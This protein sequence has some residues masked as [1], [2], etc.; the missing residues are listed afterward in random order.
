MSLPPPRPSK[1]EPPNASPFDAVVFAGGGCRCFWQS[2]FWS[3]VADELDIAPRT[4]S[5]VSAGA[6]FACAALLGATDRVIEDFKRRTALNPRNAYPRNALRGDRVFPH[7]AMYRGAIFESL[8]DVDLERLRDGPDLRILLARPPRWAGDRVGFLVGGVAYALD[9]YELRVHARW[10][11]RF[12]FEAEV[13]SA[14]DCEDVGAL[15]DLILHSSATPPLLP[16][17]R[18][19]GRLVFD[20]GLIDNAPVRWVGESHSTLVLLTRDYPAQI[21]PV[22][23][24][25][26]YVTPSQP[27]RIVKWDYTSPDLIQ[28]TFD[29][30]RRDGEAFAARW[31][32]G[33]V[34]RSTGARPGAEERLAG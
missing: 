20:G 1:S 17:Y 34:E 28:D 27:I 23:P 11:A 3:V 31:R 12:G 5:A 22:G 33:D 21:V 9:R 6:A 16:L 24:G 19:G 8:Q 7:E 15:T 30:G 29:L 2:G 4:V 32:R 25:R 26:T 13:V 18:R 10:G 14:S